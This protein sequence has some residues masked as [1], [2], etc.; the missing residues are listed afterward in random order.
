MV[1]NGESRM[2]ATTFFNAQIMYCK[3]DE[4]HEYFTLREQS[5]STPTDIIGGH[6]SGLIACSVLTVLIVCYSLYPYCSILSPLIMMSEEA[7]LQIQSPRQGPQ[8][9]YIAGAAL[10][11][12]V[13]AAIL[14]IGWTSPTSQVAVGDCW[15]RSC[16]RVGRVVGVTELL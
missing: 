10:A 4:A 1:M 11:S 16:N 5:Q 3:V 8:G 9:L 2:E 12:F 7:P 15:G 14:T 6:R 13:G